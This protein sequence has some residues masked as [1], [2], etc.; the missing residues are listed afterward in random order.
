MKK[1]G[2]PYGPEGYL[3]VGSPAAKPSLVRPAVFQYTYPAL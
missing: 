3:T 2:L 1:S